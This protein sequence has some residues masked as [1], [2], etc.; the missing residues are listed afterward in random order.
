MPFFF[1]TASF[2]EWSGL[3]RPLPDPDSQTEGLELDEHLPDRRRGRS[4]RDPRLAA[5]ARVRFGIGAATSEDLAQET[6][7][8]PLRSHGTI[9]HAW[10]FASTLAALTLDLG[11]KRILRKAGGEMSGATRRARVDCCLPGR[12][13]ARPLDGP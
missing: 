13:Q 6:F 2:V 5:H 9:H 3:A 10:G 11:L 8:E 1:E 12:S 4:R 7:V